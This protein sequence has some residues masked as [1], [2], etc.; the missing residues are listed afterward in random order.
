MS[1]PDPSFP[2]LHIRPDRGWV[3]D[4]NGVSVVDG[5][6]HV[7]FQ[8][9][10]DEPVHGSICW[11]HA[12]SADLAGWRYE[13]VALR[14]R[15]DSIDA[16]GC[17]SGC[18]VD[19][20]GVPT[21]VY[22][23]VSGQASD[24]VVALA[25][26]DRSM[27]EWQQPDRGVTDPTPP[28]GVAE[29][30]DPYVV[31]VDGHRYAV[32]G[33]GVVGGPP[34]LL[35]YGC[36]DLERWTALGPLLD[37]ADPV[38]R[39]VAPADIWECPNLFRLDDRWVL[40]VSCLQGGEL[41]ACCYLIGDLEPAGDGLAFRARS[42]GRVDQ[43]AAFYAPQV[44]S[45]P[46]GRALLWG[47]ARDIGRDP[48]QLT[49]SGWAGALTFPRQLAVVDGVLTSRPAPELD[50]LRGGA[51]PPDQPIHARSFEVGEAGAVL[52]PGQDRLDERRA[53]AGLRLSLVTDGVAE[54]VVDE[55][56]P[57][58]VLVDGSLV[59][60]FGA[61]GVPRTVRAYP[62]EESWWVVEAV[63]ATVTELVA[64]VTDPAG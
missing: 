1:H 63:D 14:N 24:A 18:L 51:L 7:F 2:G 20:A 27:I 15:P 29:V 44:L 9:N 61:D 39:S 46:D 22:T 36:D 55:P 54:V 26:S 57:A 58:R 40:L 45:M 60:V 49:A 34:V 5:R 3:N 64:P 35:L 50:V 21:A 30:R 19:D 16:A 6:Y 59:E 52:R 33:A 25:R 56:V 17:W 42:G 38:A 32:Q 48:Q 8:Y 47:W 23:A 37:F 62:T 4:P 28:P 41:Q 11:G 13:P 10:P 43:G 53:R 31:T 12:S